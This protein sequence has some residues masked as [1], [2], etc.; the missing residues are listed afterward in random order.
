MDVD[1][2]PIPEEEFAFESNSNKEGV[3][4]L[5]NAAAQPKRMPPVQQPTS[6]PARPKPAVKR[7][8]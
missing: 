1:T 6:R 3:A 7:R 8:R 2:V 5:S 4:A